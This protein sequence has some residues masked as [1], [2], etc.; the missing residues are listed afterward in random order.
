MFKI[1]LSDSNIMVLN[2][3]FYVFITFLLAFRGSDQTMST[4]LSAAELPFNTF[5]LGLTRMAESVRRKGG[6]G[7]G[8]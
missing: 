6:G 2:N 5:G 3:I 8:L 7:G 4:S 1:I